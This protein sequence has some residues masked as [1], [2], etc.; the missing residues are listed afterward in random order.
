MPSLVLMPPCIDDYS[1]RNW[2][3]S[4]LLFPS[5]LPNHVL[6]RRRQRFDQHLQTC[7]SCQ[8]LYNIERGQRVINSIAIPFRHR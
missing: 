5:G 4:S 2:E 6:V 8:A 7:N 1:Y 3:N